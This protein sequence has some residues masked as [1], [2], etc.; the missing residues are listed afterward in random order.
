MNS[1]QVKAYHAYFGWDGQDLGKALEIV[2]KTQKVSIS[3]LVRQFW[4]MYG[5]KISYNKASNLIDRLQF[6]GAVSPADP[7]NGHRREV[8]W[9]F[10]E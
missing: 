9:Q 8:Q 4:A 2:M 7:R 5:L 3:Y 1:Q 10:P 6:I